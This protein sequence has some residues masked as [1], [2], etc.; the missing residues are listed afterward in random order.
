[1]R[2]KKPLN[3]IPRTYLSV[4]CILNIFSQTLRGNIAVQSLYKIICRKFIQQ[5]LDT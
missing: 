4:L 3:T 5:I 2:N 1:M